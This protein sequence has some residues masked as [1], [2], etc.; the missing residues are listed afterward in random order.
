MEHPHPSPASTL[1]RLQ[2]QAVALRSGDSTRNKGIVAGGLLAPGSAA[3]ELPDAAAPSRLAARPGVSAVRGVRKGAGGPAREEPQVSPD[4]PRRQRLP[5][6][7]FFTSSHAQ[8]TVLA[9]HRTRWLVL[10]WAAE[11][12]ASARALRSARGTAAVAEAVRAAEAS[13]RLLSHAVDHLSYLSTTKPFLA[14]CVAYWLWEHGGVRAHLGELARGSAREAMGDDR[15][16]GPRSVPGD[17]GS[18]RL[19]KAG[20]PAREAFLAAAEVILQ[21]DALGTGGLAGASGR[22][23]RG[24]G[25]GREGGG[26]AG[27]GSKGASEVSFMSL[28]TPGTMQRCPWPGAWD[29]W[30]EECLREAQVL[31]MGVWGRRVCVRVDGRAR[32]EKGAG[33]HC[34]LGVDATVSSRFAGPLRPNRVPWFDAIA[35]DGPV[36]SRQAGR[37]VMMACHTLFSSACLV[38]TEGARASAGGGDGPRHAPTSPTGQHRLRHAG[39]RD[40]G[41]FRARVGGG[42]VRCL[43]PATSVGSAASVARFRC[44]VGCLNAIIWEPKCALQLAHL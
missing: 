5:T 10:S 33:F 42:V 35:P 22:G 8:P 18:P 9:C 12:P 13:V 23:W 2:V 1:E 38:C 32:A 4:D 25:P 37:S 43:I 20:R 3:P 44:M 26:G 30:L 14:G 21:L 6:A 28:L 15:D 31:R 36:C 16:R 27:G 34:S 11:G 40:A 29:P 41:T 7:L 17:G 24:G 39:W 19:P